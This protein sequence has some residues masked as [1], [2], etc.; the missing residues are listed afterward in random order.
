MYEY[1]LMVKAT[2]LTSEALAAATGHD[3]VGQ[4]V[5]A[6]LGNAVNEVSRGVESFQG[7]GWEI[8]S[9]QLTTFDRYF[10]TS[11]LLRRQ[12]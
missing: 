12:K 6:A 1:S 4:T 10:I 11:F 3:N 9:H 8:I 7:G 5:L 2:E